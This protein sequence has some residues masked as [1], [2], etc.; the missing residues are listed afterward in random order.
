MAN[1]PTVAR[2]IRVP[3]GFVLAVLYLWLAKADAGSLALGAVFVIMGLAIRG[4]ASGYLDKNEQL[5][6]SGPYAYTRNPLYLGSVIMA[7][8]FAIAARNL[9]IALVLAAV[10]V[11]IYLPVIRAEETYLAQRFPEFPEYAR[12]VPRFG[13][14]FQG[15]NGKRGS[16]S[17]TLYWKHRE[18]NAIIGSGIILAALIAKLF[19]TSR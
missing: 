17:W 16:F 12:R 18:Y 2:R 7:V 3:S 4:V 15:V 6:T 11:G 8:G 19:W 13:P 1:W 9:W 10:F 5:A 14:T